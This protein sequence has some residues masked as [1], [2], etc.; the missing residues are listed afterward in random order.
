MAPAGLI[1]LELDKGSLGTKNQFGAEHAGAAQRR[2]ATS[3]NTDPQRPV[4]FVTCKEPLLR[5]LTPRR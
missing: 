3:I 2:L 4:Q 1:V 5:D